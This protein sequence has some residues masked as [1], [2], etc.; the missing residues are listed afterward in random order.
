[1]TSEEARIKKMEKHSTRT[2]LLKLN[3]TLKIIFDFDARI[4]EDNAV[5]VEPRKLPCAY[6][7]APLGK[8]LLE[9]G[10]TQV[11]LKIYPVIK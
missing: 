3:T 5:S 2:N 4:R 9:L 11:E 8:E 1:M 7:Y 10:V 6:V